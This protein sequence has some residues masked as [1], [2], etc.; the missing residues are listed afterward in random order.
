[1]YFLGLQY[2]SYKGFHYFD[3]DFLGCLLQ[4]MLSL[5]RCFFPFSRAPP[6]TSPDNLEIISFLGVSSNTPIPSQQEPLSFHAP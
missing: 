6:S 5:M 2:S 1:M 3:K 4:D